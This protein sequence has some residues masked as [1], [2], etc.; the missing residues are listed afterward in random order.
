[1]IP[2]LLGLHVSAATWSLLGLWKDNGVDLVVV[3]HKVDLQTLRDVFWKVREV[4][5]V[6]SRQD[7]AGHASTPG[8]SRTRDTESEEKLSMNSHSKHDSFPKMVLKNTLCWAF[9]FFF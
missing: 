3:V 2:L 5:F 1:M 8:L 7:D 6:F 4:L 9:F